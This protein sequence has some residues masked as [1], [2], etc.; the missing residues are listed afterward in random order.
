MIVAIDRGDKKIVN[1]TRDTVFMH[2]DLLWFVSPD[3]MT[4]KGFESKLVKI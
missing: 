2:N 1:P 3:E 4:L